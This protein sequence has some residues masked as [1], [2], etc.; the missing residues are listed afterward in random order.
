V[1]PRPTRPVYEGMSPEEASKAKEIYNQAAGEWKGEVFKA[2]KKI[3][4]CEPL[5]LERW[6]EYYGCKQDYQMLK[7]VLSWNPR[8]VD[9]DV[10]PGCYMFQAINKNFKRKIAG[11]RRKR[12]KRPQDHIPLQ[13]TSDECIRLGDFGGRGKNPAFYNCE[14]K[15]PS[16]PPLRIKGRLPGGLP[17]GTRRFLQGVAITKEADGWWAAVRVE[18]PVRKLPPITEGK[19]IGIDVGLNNIAA[20]D[21]GSRVTNTRDR[22]Y[23]VQIADLQR[24]NKPTGRLQQAQARHVRHK[25]YEQIVKRCADAE[26]IFVEDVPSNLGQRGQRHISVMLTVRRLL[27]ARYG[28]RVRAVQPAYTSQDCSNCGHRDKAAWSWDTETGPIGTCPQ[29]EYSAHR[30]VNAARNIKAKGLKTYSE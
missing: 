26:T 24:Q 29:C 19:V 12:H 9:R 8:T 2:T 27:E 14:V 11:Q 20:F 30:D 7:R 3:P 15:L 28:D 16:S 23:S 10:A 25:I 13:S 1:G 18:V 4:G 21:D 17:H 6:M 22:Y 5:W